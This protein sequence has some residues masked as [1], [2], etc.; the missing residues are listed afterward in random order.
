[1]S[2]SATDA[3]RTR[4][5]TRREHGEDRTPFWFICLM[6][7]AESGDREA[8]AALRMLTSPPTV[9]GARE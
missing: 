3:T 8:Q 1:M 2:T 4:S 7:T 9:G 6:A 5:R